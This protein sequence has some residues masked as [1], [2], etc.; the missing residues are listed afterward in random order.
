MCFKVDEYHFLV[1]HFLMVRRFYHS[2]V[3]TVPFIT[4]A[5]HMTQISWSHLLRMST[6]FS[7]PMKIKKN[8][9]RSSCH[10]LRINSQW[11][12]QFNF[13]SFNQRSALLWNVIWTPVNNPWRTALA[14]PLLGRSEGGDQVKNEFRSRFPNQN[15][16]W[17]RHPVH[18]WRPFPN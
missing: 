9:S 12:A 1:K 8:S 16:F 7:S 5:P 18:V 17:N 3:V 6:F 10:D 11:R 13:M 4:P 2:Q 14:N 15:I